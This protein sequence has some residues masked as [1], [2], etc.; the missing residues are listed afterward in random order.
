MRD[1]DKSPVQVETVGIRSVKTDAGVEVKL[2]TTEL[3]SLLDQPFEQSSSV[4]A[5]PCFWQGRE[6]VDVEVVT[7]GKPVA[8]AKARHGGRAF[9]P[10]VKSPNQPVAL[11]SLNLVDLLDERPLIGEV[12]TKRPH[13]VERQ[14]GLGGT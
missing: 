2:D 13:G 11:R 1:D 6:V 10:L 5:L 9:H 3:P 8:R 14:A 12:G 7:P 4:A